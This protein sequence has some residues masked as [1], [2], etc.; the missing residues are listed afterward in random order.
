MA[1]EIIRLYNSLYYACLLSKIYVL[2]QFHITYNSPK[3]LKNHLIF[4]T[5]VKNVISRSIDGTT[6]GHASPNID[7]KYLI[8]VGAYYTKIIVMQYV[9]Y[10]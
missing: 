10:E 8:W 1:F 9:L 2:K 5:W 3:K 4:V 7:N 6:V